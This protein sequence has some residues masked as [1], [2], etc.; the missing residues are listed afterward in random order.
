MVYPAHVIFDFVTS[1]TFLFILKLTPLSAHGHLFNMYHRL[2]IV[3]LLCFVPHKFSVSIQNSKQILTLNYFKI[4]QSSAVCMRSATYAFM[5]PLTRVIFVSFS[6]FVML[7]YRQ[8]HNGN[9]FTHLIYSLSIPVLSTF[10]YFR[11]LCRL[12]QKSR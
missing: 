8:N 2:K 6:I 5:S 3:C 7:F 4:A 10:R 12:F 1:L 11:S 9:I